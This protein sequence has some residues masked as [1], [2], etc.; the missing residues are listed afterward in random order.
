M[1]P[2]STFYGMGIAAVILAI[3][4]FWELVGCDLYGRWKLRRLRRAIRRDQ[5]AYM[6]RQRDARLREAMR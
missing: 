5:V 6:Q 3:F 1:W 4:V 2:D